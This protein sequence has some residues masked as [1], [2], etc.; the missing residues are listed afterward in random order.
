MSDDAII[1]FAQKLRQRD[2]IAAGN[3]GSALFPPEKAGR[4]NV[5]ARDFRVPADFAERNLDAL[6]R[7]ARRTSAVATIGAF[8]EV[9]AW[10][11]NPRNAAVADDD[12]GSLARIA[13][14]WQQR[15]PGQDTIRE[16]LPPVANFRNFFAGV[17]QSF[18]QGGVQARAGLRAIAAD[19]VP[20]ML[21]QRRN[22]PGLGDFGLQNAL[23]DYQ[24]ATSRADAATP[25]FQTRTM[26][27]LYSG[28]SSTAQMIPSVALGMVAGP[29]AGVA[30]LAAPVGLDAYGKYR[31]RGAT[32]S[33]AG[34]G[35]T[36]EAAVEAATEFL[37]MSFM[38]D[39]LGRLGFRPFV[40]GLLGRE[41][42]GEQVA[43]FAQ[44]AID[45][46]IAN[47]DKT[48]GDFLRER[49]DAAYQTFVA[50]LV[51]GVLAGGA[52]EV[53]RHIYRREQVAQ[54]ETDASF[55]Q[56]LAGNVVES[57]VAKRDPS[58]FAQFLQMQAEGGPA[59]NVYIPGERIAEF[60]QSQDMDY[61]SD[62]SPFSFDTSIAD[63]VDEAVATGGDVVI[64]TSQFATHLA[65]TPAWEALKDH[66]R[67]SPGG[68]SLAEARDYAEAYEATREQM[69]E[70]FASLVAQDQADQE[71]RERLYQSVRDK[72]VAA[73]F[74]QNAADI[75]AALVAA[76]YATRAARRGE[77]LTGKEFD[78]VEVN[79]VLPERL[80]PIVATD[81]LGVVIDAMKRGEAGRQEPSNAQMTDEVRQAADELAA[82]LEH[83]GI[84][85]ATASTTDIRQAV[86]RYQAAQQEGRGYDQDPAWSSAIDR[87]VR[88]D[89]RN[90][91]SAR[92]GP[93]P[94]VLKA[95][96][97]S[98]G[99]LYMATG[100]IARVRREHPELPLSVMKAL[101]NLLADPFSAFPSA[102]GDGSI[103]AVVEAKDVDGNPVIAA[104]TVDSSAKHNVVLT[105]F[106]KEAGEAWI[107]NQIA[108]AQR[109]GKTVYVR[110]D[111]A[112]TVAEAPA[113]EEALS[114]GPIPV[115]RPAGSTRKILTLRDVVKKRSLDQSY[116]DGPRGRIT[117][118]TGRTVIDLFQARDPSTFLHESGHLWLE[119]L[120]QD[121]EAAGVPESIRADWETVKAWFA[122]NGHRIG[123]DGVIPVDA[124]EL[125]ARG[126]ERF[127]MEGKA[128]SPLLRRV[129]DAFRSWLLAIYQVVN[130]LRT[131]ITPEIRDV[132]S[133]LLATDAEIEEARDEQH[134]KALWSTA[135]GAGMTEE[136][137]AQYQKLTQDARDEA[138]DALL[139]RTMSVIR[140][141]RTKAWREEQESVRSE[142]TAR[143][144]ARPEFR[145][146]RTLRSREERV[147]LD[148]AWIVENYGED[149]LAMLPGAVPP[150]FADKETTA[151]DDIAEMTGFA[152]GDDLVRTLMAIGTR[153]AEMV[154]A[155]DKRS[156]RQAMIEDETAAIMRDRH[157]DPLS[158]GSI[159]EEALALVHND[160]Q[161]EVIAS[162]LRELGRRSNRRP[163]PYALARQWAAETIAQSKVADS[164]SGAALQ[165]YARA[166]RNAAKLAEEAMLAGNVDETFRQK[167][168]QMLNNALVA[169][170]GKAKAAVDAAAARLSK[171]G[172]RA[173]MK[174]VD[175]GY[176]DQAHGLLEQVD[177]RQR[178]QRSIDRQESFEA[179]AAAREAEGF[180]IVVPA[181]FEAT[182]GKQNWTRLT[183]E[184]LLGLRDAVDQVLHLGRLKQTL[185]DN[186][187]RREF[188]AV[189]AEAVDA[190]GKLPPRPPS[191]L[192]EPGWS[193]RI[194]SGVASFDAALLKIE[195]LIDWLDGGRSDG[196]FNRIVFRP[197]A[198][199]QDRE[200]DMRVDY[201]QRVV[202]AMQA[203]PPKTITRWRDMVTAPELLNRETGNPW[204]L[205]RQQLVA[206][207]LNMGNEGNIQRLTDGYG[208]SEQAVRDVL[209]RELRAD[210]WAFVQRVWDIIDSLWPQ[211]AAM[212]KGLNGVEPERVSATGFTNAHGTFRGGYYPAVYD[213]SRSI[214]AEVHQ[215]K[216]QDLFETVYTRA[217]TRASATKDRMEKVQR[218]IW[219][220]LGVI[221]RH[222]GEVI[223]DVTHREAI[224][225]AARF[226]E[227]G[228]VVRAID[229]AIGPDYR[230]QLRPW[231]KFI[232]NQWA[233]ERSGNEGVGKFINR[234]RANATVVGMGFRIG[235]IIS[236]LA[237][238]ANSA[239][240][241]GA[242]WVGEGIV[243]TTAAP[244][245]SFRF[246][247]KRSGEIRHRMDSLDRDVRAG[248]NQLEGKRGLGADV[249]RF[250]FHGIGLA[251]RLVV[252]PTWLGA[253][254]K[255]IAAGA[256]EDAAI[257]AA[258]KAVR[259]SQGAGSAKDLAAI[260]RGTG[261]WG[262]AMKLF[263][264]FYSYMSALYQRER[265][266]GR[267]IRQAGIR[268]MP[269]L[270][271]RA[272]WL[273]II[274]PVLTGLLTGRGPDDDEDWGMWTFK[275]A[276]FNALGPI[277]I[278]RDLVQPVWSAVTGE[279]GFDYQLSPLQ[280]AGQS[281]VNL[282]K[283]VGRIIAGDE[284]K[285][286]TRDALEAAGYV[287][288]LVPGQ[289]AA[290]AQ[291]LIDVAEGD[292][293]PQTVA[294]WYEGLTKGK[295]SE[296]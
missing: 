290:S 36:G 81:Q 237:G 252:I 175:Q 220:N 180:D 3:I 105:V 149:A 46:A 108:A 89:A 265:T 139:Y 99:D 272:L 158:D 10:L 80:A 28:A 260:Q 266:L 172:K 207:A 87:V 256:Q 273:I 84:D 30:A 264:M 69:G 54:A 295:M 206:M 95:L 68:V 107:R 96:G 60:F 211:I 244:I 291:F 208:W 192:M 278:L 289:I 109:E 32:P 277:P 92:L 154:A 134:I 274:P 33:M 75:N 271:S 229:D 102:R 38:V 268:D 52:S 282:G 224:M 7:E 78:S 166:A 97:L 157:G 22:G 51:P 218:P 241:V 153:K 25:D 37:P 35:A 64:P 83:E 144:D 21:P 74:T 169:E 167:Q 44:D 150:I 55:L 223:H 13:R 285:R 259:L 18:V 62:D 26:R 226:L 286:M 145:A 45:T 294:E 29:E 179:W 120:R 188:D 189:V 127:L 118:G 280:R 255:A 94:A 115:E 176:L 181:S 9:G 126:I 110:D 197:I 216:A 17:W 114:S 225:Q 138:F 283:D 194:K 117:F 12:V 296:Q 275:N 140:R 284:T 287:T 90:M 205:T 23:A 292:Q 112:A 191:D 116:M 31:S 133:R 210:D 267:D 227:D 288:G 164:L 248:L 257:Y 165:R 239:E 231:L 53:G 142:V 86:E 261:K 98:D 15:R 173:T 200:N 187:E 61:R 270:L 101:P 253:Y 222:L 24:R 40:A 276:L 263:T 147:R 85:P 113:S 242:R 201:Q 72:L 41:V 73:G 124:H 162:E 50:T 93:T 57:K 171:V 217:T 2:D 177:F 190:A 203:M 20:A 71:P 155:G 212:E 262:E 198:E 251:D 152:T 159:E 88:G 279:R 228:R 59:E 16:E 213:P 27:G 249:V 254:N 215:G 121:A 163:T 82:L 151:A 143:V 123:D 185:I 219:L 214:E 195:T 14:T 56:K 170:A 104:L 43:T 293:D 137:F 199:A 234:A 47:P 246:V 209:D 66:I 122:A 135:A 79:Q 161:G 11:S 128:P 204:Q 39:S 70:Q 131:P 125:W 141:Q 91:R 42:P 233:M 240:Y 103:I 63:Q 160:R 245:A 58:A 202:D 19:T 184:Q 243:K 77:M 221:N 106:G 146:L 136:V 182:I 281:I 76:R 269:A 49:P 186:K 258:D 235:T 196:V 247:M 174:S 8:P 178:S 168:R 230:K 129:F 100:K 236:Q 148:R 232:A 6:E 48:W 5:L 238:Y 119:E 193:D 65:G 183:V 67:L 111:P 4:A 250:A 130:N 1:S 132:M 34:I 156:V